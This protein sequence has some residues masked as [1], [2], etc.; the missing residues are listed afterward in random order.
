VL[1]CVPKDAPPKRY[2]QNNFSISIFLFSS[3]PIAVAVF[4]LSI[5]PEAVRPWFA[6]GWW[7]YV[8][9][10]ALIVTI[11]IVTAIVLQDF[12]SRPMAPYVLKMQEAKRACR[13]EREL[14]IAFANS[15]HDQEIEVKKQKYKKLTHIKSFKDLVKRGGPIAYIHIALT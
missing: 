1:V 13:L 11:L 14:R 5:T 12:M 9:A 3:F 10:A 15:V 7:P 6:E 4:A 2:I 8:S